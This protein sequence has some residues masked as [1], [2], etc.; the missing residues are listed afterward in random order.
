MKCNQRAGGYGEADI[1]TL[2]VSFKYLFVFCFF[3]QSDFIDLSTVFFLLCCN[4]YLSFVVVIILQCTHLYY[5]VS[6]AIIINIV[7]SIVS[8][9]S[10]VSNASNLSNV[11]CKPCHG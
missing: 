3:L 6:G 1:R 9:G 7:I 8:I 10:N 11:F 5:I 2:F 4:C